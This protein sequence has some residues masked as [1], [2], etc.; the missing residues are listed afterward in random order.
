MCAAHKP[1]VTWART[2]VITERNATKKIHLI[3]FHH[4]IIAVSFLLQKNQSMGA[5]IRKCHSC[6]KIPLISCFS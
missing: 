5:F 4:K 2:Y 3:S 1:G 6:I